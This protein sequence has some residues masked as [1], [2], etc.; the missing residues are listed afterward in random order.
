MTTFLVLDDEQAEMLG[1]GLNAAL[2]VQRQLMGEIMRERLQR[3]ADGDENP[4]DWKQTRFNSLLH[5]VYRLEALVRMLDGTPNTVDPPSS[6]E[7]A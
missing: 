3:A 1:F 5:R 4:A 7:P 2:R 6:E